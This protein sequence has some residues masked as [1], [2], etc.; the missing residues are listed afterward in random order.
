[1]SDT[2]P[3]P[4]ETHED[5]ATTAWLETRAKLMEAETELAKLRAAAESQRI[6]AD[7]LKSRVIKAEIAA[8]RPVDAEAVEALVSRHIAVSETG[9]F[10]A[11]MKS[12]HPMI[13]AGPDH[14]NVS[15]ETYLDAM[16]KERPALFESTDKGTAGTARAGSGPAVEMNVNSAGFSFSEAMQRA[17]SDPMALREL[18]SQVGTYQARKV[19]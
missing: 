8:R 7:T 9:E 6:H 18:M 5:P 19:I 11:V 2:T 10:Y 4:T 12:G 13:G 17:K 16:V 15:L 1:M 3:K 14:G